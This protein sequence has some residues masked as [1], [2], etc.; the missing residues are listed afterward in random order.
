MRIL[1]WL[2]S[3]G[4][5]VGA[6]GLVL[7]LLLFKGLTSDLPDVSQLQNYNP[8]I[9][10]RVHA[11]DGRLMAEFAAERRV[12][13]PISRIPQRVIDAFLAA[14]DKNFYSHPGVDFVGIARAIVNNLKTGSMQGASTITQQV[15]KNFLI[16]NERSYERKVREAALAFRMEDV[17]SKDEILELYLNEIFLGMRAYGVASAALAYFNKTLDELTIAEAAYLAAL[18]KAPN[19]YH[20]VRNKDRALARRNWVL[21]RMLEDNRITKE[22]RDAA[23]AQPIE[24]LPRSQDEFYRGGDYFTEEVRRDLVARYGEKAVLEG[25]LLV[26]ATLDPRLQDIATT[27]LRRGLIEYDRRH[28]WRGP[29]ARVGRGMDM[30]TALKIT[31]IPA[32]GEIWQLAG[33]TDV[34]ANS[35]SILLADATR[36]TIPLD[37]LKWARSRKPGQGLGPAIG[38]ASDALSVGDIILVEKLADGK[39]YTLRQI[40]AVQGGLVAMDANTGRV[41][42]MVGGFSPRMS[43]FNR[44]T[45]A[46]RQP[47]SSF[48]PFVYMAALESGFTPSTLVLDAPISL[49]QGPGLPMWTPGNY[50]NDYLGPTTLRVGMEKSRNVMT[51]RLAQQVGINKVAEVAES[52]G[53]V[54]RL[55]RNLSMSLGAGETTVMRMVTAYA[56]MVNGGRKLSPTMI[57]SIQDKD[58]RIIYRHDARSCAECSNILWRENLAVPSL[59][60]PRAQIIDPRTA[61][62]MVHILEGVIERGTGT[63]VKGL[64]W[65]LAGKTGTTND[66]RDAWFVG[67]SS[68]MAVG[69]YLGFDQPRTLGDH[70][71]GGVAAA[72][73]F[74]EFMEG[75]LAG[76]P[77]VPFRVPSGLRLVRVNAASG[78][79]AEPG[80]P[81]AIW[82]AFKPGTEPHPGQV[83]QT[84]DPA[85]QWGMDN[86]PEVIQM[87]GASGAVVQGNAASEEAVTPM[88]SLPSG[89]DQP[90]ATSTPAQQQAPADLTQQPDQGLPSYLPEPQSPQNSLEGIY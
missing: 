67:F 83:E 77:P 45:Q 53:V 69:L 72:P 73:V 48:K 75:A 34:S 3:L 27:A 35:A 63:R 89:Q 10:S 38:K 19:D 58:G 15:A 71:T 87:P 65:P 68:D 13:V 33:V 49:P 80:D 37:E 76:T 50:T 52:F 60:D 59:P 6:A 5:L 9:V 29:V 66:A 16:G 11:G 79:L 2:L 74:R 40:P 54:D 85:L 86:L 23:L 43:S 21:D 47:G 14:E 70:E 4:M 61:Y 39:A 25:G 24:M 46:Q 64:P 12:F 28:G 81:K 41:L 44:A 90:P 26:R 51:V 17:Y 20:P 57:D 55:Q 31:P 62:Q 7:A 36:S 30:Q 82:E 1:A 56:Q 88:P 78:R 18:P 8:P 42:A 84:I 22:E 32:G